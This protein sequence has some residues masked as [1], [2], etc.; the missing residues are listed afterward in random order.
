MTSDYPSGKEVQAM[1][2]QIVTDKGLVDLMVELG[3]LKPLGKEKYDWTRQFMTSFSRVN[4]RLQADD[5]VDEKDLTAIEGM[6]AVLTE[7]LSNKYGSVLYDKST[8][9]EPAIRWFNNEI[10]DQQTML[11]MSIRAWHERLRLD[12]GSGFDLMDKK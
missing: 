8:K 9:E 3:I 12:G 7:Y 4:M 11:A 2:R 1:T 5:T 6:T 10:L